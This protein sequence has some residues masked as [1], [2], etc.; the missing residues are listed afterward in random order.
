MRGGGGGGNRGGELE[1]I[2]MD[3]WADNV[4]SASNG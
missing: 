4:G 1:K 2:W 3:R